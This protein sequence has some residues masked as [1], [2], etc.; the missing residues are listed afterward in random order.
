MQW[1]A[2]GQS[3]HNW[4]R[5]ANQGLMDTEFRGAQFTLAMA[6]LLLSCA[7][8][9]VVCE[10]RNQQDVSPDTPVHAKPRLDTSASASELPLSV[11][12]R[13]LSRLPNRRSPR[14]PAV[15]LKDF[16][17]EAA[18]IPERRAVEVG[19]HRPNP[20]DLPLATNTDSTDDE[21][22]AESEVVFDEPRF[23]IESDPIDIRPPDV[24]G[25][26]V[27]APAPIPRRSPEPDI[28]ATPDADVDDADDSGSIPE[29][30]DVSL[31]RES[32]E[33]PPVSVSSPAGIMTLE[34]N[35]WNPGDVGSQHGDHATDGRRSAGDCI[36]GRRVGG[37]TRT[38]RIEERR[39][40]FDREGTE[41]NS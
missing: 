27:P 20:V 9:T 2:G 34:P 26:A 13:R 4:I 15:R 40:V 1:I 8:L 12:K 33:S 19:S 16:P 30:T 7:G 28:A 5:I 11:S 14:R 32:M 31:W 24:D 38:G 41:R 36:V 21:G 6:A 23:E 17:S 18:T 25:P 22:D 3:S 39:F 29:A 37:R 10:R 35:E